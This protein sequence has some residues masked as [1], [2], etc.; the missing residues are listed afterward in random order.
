[1]LELFKKKED[2]IKLLTEPIVSGQFSY[3]IQR[4]EE[5]KYHTVVGFTDDADFWK[6]LTDNIIAINFS[7]KI[8]G[9]NL[10]TMR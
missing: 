3:Y 7:M 5:E 9:L 8:T 6:E 2:K 4:K 1:M 10:H